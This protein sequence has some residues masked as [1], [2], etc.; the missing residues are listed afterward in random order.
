[1]PRTHDPSPTSFR[2]RMFQA[3]MN[4][5]LRSWW[6]WAFL[7]RR[8]TCCRGQRQVRRVR[9]PWNQEGRTG[10]QQQAVWTTWNSQG[11]WSWMQGTRSVRGHTCSG[12][13]GPAAHP[14]EPPAALGF[15]CRCCARRACPSPPRSM[16]GQ[17]AVDPHGER[18]HPG[19]PV[20]RAGVPNQTPAGGRPTTAPQPTPPLWQP[21]WPGRDSMRL[22][23]PP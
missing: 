16:R 3:R 23:A 14:G 8:T 1:M 15:G 17:E 13:W 10:V 2:R 21:G 5:T 12:R 7:T 9:R 18:R 4:P 20:S 11:A 22:A 6:H 19:P